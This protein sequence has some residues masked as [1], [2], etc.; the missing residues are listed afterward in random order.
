MEEIADLGNEGNEALVRV[1]VIVGGISL[2]EELYLPLEL[3]QDRG[4]FYYRL[5]TRDSR[6]SAV[7]ARTI[8]Q[9]QLV[10]RTTDVDLPTMKL[11]LYMTLTASSE[12]KDND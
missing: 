3:P 10:V 5:S 6:G 1:V 2:K 12:G 7:W 8:K 9:Q 4:R 11:A